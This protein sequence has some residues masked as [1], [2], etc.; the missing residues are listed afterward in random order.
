MNRWTLRL[1]GL[2][3]LIL[4]GILFVYSVKSMTAEW[5][6]IFVGLLSV[7]FS[8]MGFG[9]L[10]MPLDSPEKTFSKDESNPK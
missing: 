2:A 4:G 10:I 3:S 5:P 6:Q 7:F 8:A 9:L 1:I